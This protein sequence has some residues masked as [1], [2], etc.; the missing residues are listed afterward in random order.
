MAVKVTNKVI[1]TCTD[2]R[3]KIVLNKGDDV[4][5]FISRWR[6]LLPGYFHIIVALFNGATYIMKDNAT[7][8][9]NVIVFSFAIHNF[10][11][12]L[13]AVIKYVLLFPRCHSE[14]CFPVHIL[15]F[16]HKRNTGTGNCHRLFKS[17]LKSLCTPLRCVTF[18]PGTGLV[19]SRL[20]QSGRS[21]WNN[22]HIRRSF[23]KPLWCNISNERFGLVCEFVVKITRR[24]TIG[25]FLVSAEAPIH[26]F[27]NFLVTVVCIVFFILHLL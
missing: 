19:P 4:A 10:K 17:C 25:S 5:I 24:P 9:N 3:S 14:T 1:H 2:R 13:G 21:R 15:N 22:L 23:T 20:S 27:E 16:L 18:F 8:S 12:E 6:A 26:L 7:T 11:F